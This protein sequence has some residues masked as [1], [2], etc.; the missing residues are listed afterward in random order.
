MRRLPIYILLDES[1]DSVVRE[2]MEHDLARFLRFLKCA[3]HALETVYLSIIRFGACWL[4]KNPAPVQVLSFQSVID[5]SLDDSQKSNDIECLSVP[6]GAALKLAV[7]SVQRERNPETFS[8]WRPRFV[9]L[10]ANAPTDNWKS[11][12]EALKSVN[13]ARINIGYY[14]NINDAIAEIIKLCRYGKIH[15]CS[16]ASHSFH[17]DGFWD[18]FHPDDFRDWCE[19]GAEDSIYDCDAPVLLNLPQLEEIV[20]PFDSHAIPPPPPNQENPFG[21]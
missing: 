4:I 7:S 21:I 17:T 18:C 6:L 12:L 3:P 11:G 19:T 8:D 1:G 14:G 10:S 5:I 13:W 15:D 16:L 2:R 20:R 9:L